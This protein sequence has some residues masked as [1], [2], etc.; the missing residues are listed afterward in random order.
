MKALRDRHKPINQRVTT[1]PSTARMSA[2]HKNESNHR[3]IAI[4][5]SKAMQI[6]HAAAVMRASGAAFVG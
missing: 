2:L 4:G 6:F 3:F 5:A 1:S